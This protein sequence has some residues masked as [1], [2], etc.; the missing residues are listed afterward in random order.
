MF[1]G[2]AVRIACLKVGE[3][4]LIPAEEFCSWD[5][6]LLLRGHGVCLIQCSVEHEGKSYSLSVFENGLQ[7]VRVS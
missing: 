3:H 1:K 2:W 6:S 4:E 5:C 7:I